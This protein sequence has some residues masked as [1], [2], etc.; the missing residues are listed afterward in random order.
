MKR[1]DTTSKFFTFPKENYKFCT[2]TQKNKKNLLFLWGTMEIF[3]KMK[4]NAIIL[5][6]S[7]NPTLHFIIMRNGE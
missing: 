6:Y 1:L 7:V 2:K 5:F 4:R 3:I